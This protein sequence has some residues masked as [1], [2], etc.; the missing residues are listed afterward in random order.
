MGWREDLSLEYETRYYQNRVKEFQTSYDVGTADRLARAYQLG[1]NLSPEVTVP[2][3]LG[4]GDETL[5]QQANRAAIEKM[6]ADGNGRDADKRRNDPDTEDD[7]KSFFDS[8]G[9]FATTALKG[10]SRTVFTAMDS[11]LELVTGA[12][13]APFAPGARERMREQGIFDGLMDYFIDLPKQTS[14][15]EVGSQFANSGRIDL[16]SGYF[17]GGTV[18]TGQA[19]RQRDILGT[20]ERGGTTYGFTLGRGF[21]E[22]LAD[23][24]IIDEESWAWNVASGLVDATLAV[25]ADPSNLVPGVGWG[26]ELVQGVKAVGSRRSKAFVNLIERADEAM[27]AG[28]LAGA[29]RLR[30]RA[31]D[32]IGADLTGPTVR[33]ANPVEVAI[34]DQLMTDIGMNSGNIRT[35]DGAQFYSYLTT[36]AGTRLVERMVAETRPSRVF[37]LHRG[38]IGPKAAKELAEATSPEEVIGVY[39]RAF[40]EPS[41]DL[42]NMVKAVPNLGLF[43][44]T[45]MGLWVRRN[46]NAHTK[47]GRVMPESSVLD[48][49]KPSQYVQ[50]L[51]QLLNVL[52]I[53]AVDE[54]GKAARYNRVLRDDLLDEAINTLAEADPARVFELNNKI[55]GTFAEMF[56][57]L[58]YT[59]E[60]VKKLVR[61]SEEANQYMAFAMNQIASGEKPDKIP[62]LVTQLL[63]SGAAVIDPKELDQMV[64]ESGN[65]R[66]LI[67]TQSGTGKKYFG[68]LDEIDAA[69]ASLADAVEAGDEAAA[70]LARAQ[71]DRLNRDL[72]GLRTS[73]DQTFLRFLKGVE[74]AGE[75]A[76]SRVWKPLQLIRPAFVVRVVAEETM[77]TLHSGTFGGPGRTWDY[78]RAAFRKG[79]ET[80]AIGQRF[81]A[82]ADEYAKLEDDVVELRETMA[83]LRVAGKTD[84]ADAIK[85][86]IAELDARIDSI[87]DEVKAAE[88]FYHQATL[89]NNPGSAYAALTKN[90]KKMLYQ[91]GQAGNVR[92]TDPEQVSRWVQGTAD[93]VLKFS[94]D[95]VMRQIARGGPGDEAVFTVNGIADNMRNHILAGNVSSTD[96]A[97][98]YWLMEGGGRE[99]LD[100]IAGAY[101]AGGEAFNPNN[102]EDVLGW[103]GRMKEELRYVTGGRI[104]PVTGELVDFDEDLMEVVRSQRFRGR[105]VETLDKKGRKSTLDSAYMDH[106]TDFASRDN[107]PEWMEYLG[108]N[109]YG[110]DKVALMDRV[111]GW[112]FTEMYGQSSDKLARS[113]VFRR[114]YWKQMTQLTDRLSPDEAAKLV[115]RAKAAN[116][117]PRLVSQIEGRAKIA[118]GTNTIEDLDGVAKAAGLAA[119]RDLLFDATRRDATF[120]QLRLIIPFGDAWKEVMQTWGNLFVRQR[121][122][123]AYR[124]LRTGQAALEA[125]AGPFGPG[126]LYGIDPV[127]GEFTPGLDGENEG[128]IYTDPVAKDKRVMIP[129][130]RQL[131]QAVLK[132]GGLENV[133]GVAMGIPIRNMSIAGG[134]L[135]GI[136]PVA[137]RA[138][139]GVIPDDPGFDWVRQALFPFGAPAGADT[140]GGQQGVEEVALSAWQQKLAAIVPRD[141]PVLGWLANMAYDKQDDPQYQSTVSQMY[142]SLMT[143]GRYTMSFEDQQQAQADAER[144]ADKILVM[145]GLLQ[146]TAPG[147]PLPTYMARTEEGDVMAALLVDQLRDLEEVFI[148]KGDNANKAL[149]MMLDTY[150]PDIWLYAAPVSKPIYKGVSATDA[151]WDWYRQNSATASQYDLIGGFLG[152]AEGEFSIDAYGAMQREG[153]YEIGTPQERYETAARELGFLAFNRFR[154]SLPPEQYRSNAD[155]V[156]LAQVRNDIE[157][158][159]NVDLENPERRSERERQINQAESLVRAADQG[160]PGA[161]ALLESPTGDALRVYLNARANIIDIANQAGIINWQSTKR[162]AILRDGLRSIAAQLSA[163]DAGFA[164]MFQFVFD[165]EMQ[166]DLEV[167]LP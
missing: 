95:P 132:A 53:G 2:L 118:A 81:R 23:T 49:S 157:E 60:H 58:G 91:S 25:V 82:T 63:S 144:A 62:L 162:A 93:R 94:N 136:G 166:D 155:K 37:D 113:P 133:A 70:G 48:I 120:D 68:K 18:E 138:V 126:D 54:T 131:S 22:L 11:G 38:K 8:I 115:E 5:V 59:P 119:S 61:W 79:Y 21:A 69:K 42:N 83:E 139:E 105:R 159:F 165:R 147:S 112:F 56:T 161:V 50:R 20:V 164:K 72:E 39:M 87:M 7:N 26:D 128:F 71:I 146:A 88:E 3:I 109:I 51:N 10:A 145:R 74:L 67:R 96:E 110:E 100:K 73:E 148:K 55:A 75:F 89:A 46:I 154:D 104:D 36:R 117:S 111:A 1:G 149:S 140:A 17:V 152:P 78:I 33:T 167:E 41:Q 92:R 158:Y 156:L 163:G 141:W 107:A 52:P 142:A 103:V 86:Q 29:E 30:R 12:L 66:Q 6:I 153:V 84:E 116:I 99:Y 64:R 97:I 90:P 121:G 9:D 122:M 127:T 65:I 102:M 13:S 45:D 47:L 15:W 130:S 32:K 31:M 125:D 44:T 143:S 160:Q 43:R 137:D 150:G 151:W 19:Q 98:G 34:R 108:N 124:L 35:V 135:P 129:W 114:V 80:D 40:A 76:I 28:D 16:G 101:A 85:Q 27:N 24:G 123:N 106:I 14:L 57:N 134:I 4:G 77:R